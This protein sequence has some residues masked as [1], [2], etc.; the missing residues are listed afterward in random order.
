MTTKEVSALEV[1][2]QAVCWYQRSGWPTREAVFRVNDTVT[3]R[4]APG[5]QLLP[6]LAAAFGYP[7]QVDAIHRAV[8]CRALMPAP[9][10][11]LPPT[12]GHG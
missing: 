5:D 12:S 2:A 9:E 4:T 7:L 11:S 10:G 3:A 6:T 8:L 1:V